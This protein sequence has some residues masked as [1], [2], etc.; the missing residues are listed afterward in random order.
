[1]Q[2]ISPYSARPL[3]PEGPHLLSDGERCWPYLAGIP[4]LRT[5]REQLRVEAVELIQAGAIDEALALLLCDRRHT[6]IPP[7]NRKDALALARS[8][9]T[10]REAMKR[11][12]FGDMYPYVFHRWSLPTF[13][14][15]LALL[16]LHAPRKGTMLEVG[17]G[18]GHFIRAWTRGGGTA[19]GS[20]VV[21]AN[22][23]LAKTFVEPT[24]RFVCFDANRPFPVATDAVDFV[25]VHDTLHY[26]DDKPAAVAE[27]RR[28]SPS[29][30]LLAG[31]V[32]NA[33]AD[34]PSAG[35]PL[36]LAE[37]RELLS[38]VCTYDDDSLTN[39]AL[40]GDACATRGGAAEGA[41]F[42]FTSNGR[43]SAEAGAPLVMP[44]ADVR[45][46]LNPLLWERSL[47]DND[48]FQSEFFKDWPYL[49][50]L[51][52]R[53]PHAVANAFTTARSVAQMLRDR[54]L[55]DLPEGWVA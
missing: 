55:L 23:W 19:I 14:S 3:A 52:A 28:V 44:S 7:A 39:V 46:T 24:A 38:P 34:N 16:E 18:A 53:A 5:E 13:L 20:D 2:F 35:S 26:I 17:C 21:F 33:D 9:S 22:V 8:P 36:S 42:A 25:F 29:G 43:L 12:N 40:T 51:A 15:G 1:M 10:I 31:H 11:L 37:Y 4:Y 6:G 32:H 45:L 27:M 49:Q 30:T 47:V 41:A 48:K 54:T 50:N